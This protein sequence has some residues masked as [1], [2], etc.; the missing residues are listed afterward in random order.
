MRTDPLDATASFSVAQWHDAYVTAIARLDDAKREALQVSSLILDPAAFAAQAIE[1]HAGWSGGDP[2][3]QALWTLAL[4]ELIGDLPT[5]EVDDTVWDRPRVVAAHVVLRNA[6]RWV[7]PI[8]ILGDVVSTHVV[9]DCG[10]DSC[11]TIAGNLRAPALYTSGEMQLLG[12]V[13]VSLIEGHYNDNVLVVLGDVRA[14]VI[15]EEQHACN[16]GGRVTVTRAHASLD[17]LDEDQNAK[18]RAAILLEFL[19]ESYSLRAAMD[20]LVAGRNVFVW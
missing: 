7:A 11:I 4:R 15:F 2:T 8:V 19:G 16:W 3:L 10:P 17:D 20:A 14:D 13:D 9:Q 18:L 1:G 5:I 6:M 12:D